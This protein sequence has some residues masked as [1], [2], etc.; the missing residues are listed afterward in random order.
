[1]EDQQTSPGDLTGASPPDEPAAIDDAGIDDELAEA[2][3]DDPGDTSGPAK[4]PAGRRPAI[5]VGLSTVLFVGGA[6][7]AGA[8]AQP[9]LVDRALVATKVELVRT[10]TNAI[11]ALWNYTPENMDTLADRAAVYLAGDLEADYRQFIDAIAETNKQA[12][13]SD[14]T[15]ITGA[16]VESLDG[17]RATVIIYTNTSATSELTKAIPS[18]KYLSYRLSMKR[19]HR[20]WVITKMPTITSLDL[21]PR[22]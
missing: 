4:R 14:T 15:K 9:Y 21:T 5:A 7:F 18:L 16:A 11:T 17:P 1:M 13:V 19:E 20:R 2:G 6:A 8:A 10:A 3:I 12:K 22:L